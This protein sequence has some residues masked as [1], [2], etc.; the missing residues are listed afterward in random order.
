MAFRLSRN[1]CKINAILV[2]LLLAATAKA[3]S[4]SV[5]S[6]DTVGEYLRIRLKKHCNSDHAITFSNVE[7]KEK[8][9]CV[10]SM[11][12]IQDTLYADFST[13]RTSGHLV[14]SGGCP[15]SIGG[16][17]FSYREIG[18]SASFRFGIPIR[19][20][21]AAQVIAL[22]T[23]YGITYIPLHHPE[24]SST[25]FPARA[26]NG[27]LSFC[28]KLLNSDST[29]SLLLIDTET[30]DSLRIVPTA[31]LAPIPVWLNRLYEVVV[32]AAGGTYSMAFYGRDGGSPDYDFC[33]DAAVNPYGRAAMNRERPNLLDEWREPP[34]R[35]VLDSRSYGIGKRRLPLFR[36]YKFRWTYINADVLYTNGSDFQTGFA[37]KIQGA[38]GEKVRPHRNRR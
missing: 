32:N 6:I 28:P 19:R 8:L 7:Q 5:M 23:E 22:K 33:F 16:Q 29:Q 25:P 27:T 10:R 38:D 34:W 26:R 18:D 3:Q 4:V 9:T 15:Y 11:E 13:S 17:H 14:C 21:A 1:C 20:C 37:E 35:T 24:Q 30:G 31:D 12:L 36:F 2:L